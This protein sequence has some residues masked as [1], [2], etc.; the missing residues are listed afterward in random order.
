MSS[1]RLALFLPRLD[2]GGAER[3]MLQ[4]GSSFARRGHAVD[5]V[6]ATSGGPLW[7][8]IPPALAVV[9][10][11]ARR[12]TTALPDLVRYLRRAR[13]AAL[14]STLE[15]SNVLAVGAAAIA[16]KIARVSTRVVLREAN[17][18]LP[19]RELGDAKARAL[20][21]LMAGAYRGADGVVAVSDSVA[22][23]I[24]AEL[25][26]PEAR[27]RTIYNPIVT[28]D[29]ATKAESDV[30]DAWF[31]PGAPPVVLGVGRLVAQKDFATL[32]RAFARVRATRP[33]R[34]VILGEGED[35]G[36]LEALA[37]ELGVADDV[38]LPGFDHNPFRFMRRAAVFA[39]S[40]VFEGLP[41]A[42]IQAMAC[43]C[44]VVSTDCP[45][46]SSEVLEAGRLAPLVSMRDPEALARAI[47]AQLDAAARE[48]R[49]KYPVDRFTEAGAVDAYLNALGV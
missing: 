42:L 11:A 35:R 28:D 14:L 8:Q 29:L 16:R 31:T 37:R 4:L 21:L 1:K 24:V 30:D 49:A 3:V 22:R 13:P 46:G 12:T 17:V 15:H 23:T 26:L 45:G 39:L 7:S 25:K 10:L 40:S 33:A 9:D 41:G 44:R 18:L 36:A 6:L 19:W 38:R 47:A 20:R 5:L 27:V 32:V 34:L 43:G 48:G 2:D